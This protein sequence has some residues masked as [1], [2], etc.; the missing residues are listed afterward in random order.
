MQLAVKTKP[1]PYTAQCT[2]ALSAPP[3]P[4]KT[5]GPPDSLEATAKYSESAA[6]VAQYVSKNDEPAKHHGVCQQNMIPTKN[7]RKQTKLRC[8]P[9]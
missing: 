3:E 9:T 6:Q 7:Q 4:N 5:T 8:R 1:H 2:E